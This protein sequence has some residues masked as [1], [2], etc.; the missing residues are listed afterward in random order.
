MLESKVLHKHVNVSGIMLINN[1]S[2]SPVQP[3]VKRL[4]VLRRSITDDLRFDG[5]NTCHLPLE[6][7]QFLR[8]SCEHEI[9]TVC[10]TRYSIFLVVKQVLR[11]ESC[12]NLQF[13]TFSCQSRSQLLAVSLVSYMLFFI[14]PTFPA[15]VPIVSPTGNR[16]SSGLWAFVRKYA[17]DT[18]MSTIENISLW[19]AAIDIIAFNASNG[20][21]PAYR[22][23]RSSLLNSLAEA[24]PRMLCL[25]RPTSCPL[26]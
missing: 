16:I 24:P 26:E 5:V 14:N 10:Q 19:F 11:A 7:H 9:V 25:C 12:W 22:S 21:V 3:T 13:L 23:G 1:S 20:G 15:S 6:L 2:L 17:R 4:D 18:S 8:R